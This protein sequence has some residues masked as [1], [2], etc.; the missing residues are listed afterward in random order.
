MLSPVSPLH[1][2]NTQVRNTAGGALSW[3]LR[4]KQ[5]RHNQI[6]LFGS[7]KSGIEGSQ[8]QHNWKEITV[9]N[10]FSKDNSG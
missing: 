5:E 3:K 10:S 4:P 2:K 1:F 7:L 8:K 6:L 9:V